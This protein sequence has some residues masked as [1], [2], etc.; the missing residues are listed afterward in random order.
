MRRPTHLLLANSDGAWA[1]NPQ[2]SLA[3]AA[4]HDSVHNWVRTHPGCD[5]RLWVS[6]QLVRSLSPLR[7]QPTASDEAL[8]V[9]AR[10]EL[11]GSHGA[12][13]DEWALATWANHVASGVSALSGID[14]QALRGHAAQHG[15]RIQSVVP[16]WYH[17]F[18]EA[19]RCVGA[20]NRR[21]RAQVGVVEGSQVVWATTENGTLVEVQQQELENATV[22][23][24]QLEI[25]R[26]RAANA[27]QDSTCV[28]LGQGLID[29]ARTTGLDALVLGRLDGDQ[30]PQWLRPST[31]LETC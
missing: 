1:W 13:A 2:D 29:G 6:G 15:V 20:L 4:H 18:G 19:K 14:L 10:R 17:A 30:P 28:V 16:W 22:A 3:S 7:S 23:A 31:Q 27:A 24:L 26:M 5:L 11:V 12:R 8:R 25:R 21:A 9:D